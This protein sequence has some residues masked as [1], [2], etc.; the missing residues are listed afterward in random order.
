MTFDIDHI[1]SELTLQEKI[2]LLAGKDFWHTVPI[3]RLGIPSIRVC[4]GPNGIRGIRFFDATPSNCFTCGTGLASTFN[5]KLLKEVGELMGEEA[6]IKGAHVILGPTC[7]ILRAPVG[8]RAFESYSEDPLL[9]GIVASEI[10]NGIQSK[11]VL[12]CIKH[13]VCNDQEDDRKGV[14]TLV[15]ER[16]LREIYLKPFHIALRDSDPRSVMTAYNKVNGKHVSQDPYLLDDVLR[17]EWNYDGTVMSDWYGTYS[18]KEALDAGLNLEMPGPTRFRQIE[19][20]THAVVCNEIHKDVIDKN[21]RQ[22][23]QFIKEAMESG[24]PENAEEKYNDSQESKDLLRKAG[25]ESIVLLKNND[26]IL[27]LKKTDK[28]AVIGPNAKV[29]QDSGG[30]SASMNAAY[31]I[32]P[33]EG[34]SAKVDGEIPYALGAFLDKTLPDIGRILTNSKGEKGFDGEFFDKPANDKSKKS[35]GKHEFKTSRLFLND[36]AIEDELFYGEFVGSYVADESGEYE[37]GCS[38][39]GTAQIFVNGELVVDNKTKQTPGDAFFLG[40]GTREEK[41]S[42]TLE[43]GKKYEIR[44]EWGSGPTYTIPS[45][46]QEKGGVYFGLSR[47]STDEVEIQKAV[48]LAKSVDKV[49]LVVGISKEWETEGFDRPNMDIP[50]STNRLISEV[51]K[52]NKNVVVVNQSGSPVTMPWVN[53]IQGLIQAWYGGNETGNTIADVLYGDINPSGKLSVTFPVKYEHNPSYLNFGSMNG[54]V[55]YGEDIYVGY[56]YYEKVE[57]EVLFPFGYGI[58]YTTFELSDLKVSSDDKHVTVSVNVKNT[59]KVAGAE[60]VQVYIEQA[61]PSVNRAKKELKDFEKVYLQSGESSVVDI[62]FSIKEATSYWNTYKKQWISEKD[63]Y[64]VL[65]GNSSHNVVLS[66][67]FTTKSTYYWLGL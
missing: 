42:Y 52:V 62:K 33:Y 49:V 22:I 66:D 63:T 27:P 28:I 41:G 60:T 39:L 37:F 36:I 4:D 19:Q 45:Q 31:K 10:I 8:G 12:A 50:G 20:T 25:G 47:K 17:K 34:I 48:E 40:M 57:R 29:C 51:C 26:N 13:Y 58:S 16:A 54:Q 43:K 6:K 3:P 67:Q 56:R 21:A 14:D 7:N 46:Y 38:T 32:T 23:L 30:G 53:E 11:K 44:V 2:S 55:M 15:T 1:L 65:V 59:G 9:S 61:N 18:T 35:L 64:Y 24:I 5:K